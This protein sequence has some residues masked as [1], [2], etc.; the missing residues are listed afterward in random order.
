[1]ERRRVAAG[2]GADQG[3]DAVRVTHA[4]RA[5]I[6]QAANRLQGIIRR[7]GGLQDKPF[8]HD[9]TVLV[10]FVVI[11]LHQRITA[12]QLGRYGRRQRRQRVGHIVRLMI[13]RANQF[14][15]QSGFA[16]RQVAQAGVT[17]R[18]LADIGMLNAVAVEL[19]GVVNRQELVRQLFRQRAGQRFAHRGDGDRIDNRK[20]LRHFICR[21]QGQDLR[22]QRRIDLL[23]QQNRT[24]RIG[25]VDRQR[26]RLPLLVTV[27]VEFDIGRQQALRRVPAGEIIPRVA[28][29]EGQLLIA[30]FVLQ[31]HRRGKLAK[32]RRDRLEVD[33]VE[34]KSLL[35]LGHV[36]YVMHRMAALLQ[37]DHFAFVI[38]QLDIEWDMQRQLLRLF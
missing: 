18:T 32:Q 37:R 38:V 1:M 31:L 29:Q 3:T 5:M 12:R 36:Q 16:K 17:Q 6:Q 34:N 25:Y 11:L 13:L 26:Q 10:P 30:P 14:I 22:R 7:A 27:D 20:Q 8:I 33:V 21:R 28:H 9:Q 23:I 4:E 15:R 24:E 35:R 2:K 19:I